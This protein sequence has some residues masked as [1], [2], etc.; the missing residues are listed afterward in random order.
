M[1]LETWIA[2][3][4]AS[5]I[6]CFVPGPS[7]MLIISYALSQG[8]R[9]AFAMV[10]GVMLGDLV[11]IS[12]S[13]LGLGA[14]M[15][16]SATAFQ[17]LKWAG[18]AYLIYLGW[19][20]LT[21]KPSLKIHDKQTQI[22]SIKVMQHAFLVTVLNPKSIGFFVAFVP[23]FIT[24]GYEISVQF[25]ILILTYTLVGGIN[26]VLYVFAADRMRGFIQQPLTMKWVNR[27]G[28]TCLVAMGVLTATLQRQT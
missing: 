3:V 6:V 18:A 22:N 7:V 5:T 23:Q 12:A 2:Y 26:A 17:V 25:P 1:P 20:L 21:S 14:L 13:L 15:L 19:K 4:I 24:P 28:G 11:A 10:A 16:A 9:V 27:A 8:R